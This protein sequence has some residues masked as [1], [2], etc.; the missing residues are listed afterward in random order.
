MTIQ[1]FY[2]Q[3]SPSFPSVTIGGEPS[4][5]LLSGLCASARAVVLQT[6]MSQWRE[7]GNARTLCV[8]MK[9]EDEAMYMYADLQV[10][11][12]EVCVFYFPCASPED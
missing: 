12:K 1:E 11:M 6:L 4:H 10:V 9:D 2:A 3:V 7:Q 5:Y 8:V